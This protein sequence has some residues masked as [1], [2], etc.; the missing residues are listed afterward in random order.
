MFDLPLCSQV[1]KLRYRAWNDMTVGCLALLH[2]TSHRGPMRIRQDFF[3]FMFMSNRLS[4]IAQTSNNSCNSLTEGAINKMTSAYSTTRG[5]NDGRIGMSSKLYH[6]MVLGA[7]DRPSNKPIWPVPIFEIWF[8]DERI[9]NF[10]PRRPT[11]HVDKYKKLSCCRE[12]AR[13]FVP[14]NI[15]LSHKVIWNDT[16][17]YGVCKS[18]LVFHWNYVSRTRVPFLKYSSSK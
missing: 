7:R 9:T 10:L 15:S 3:S 8:D 16:L 18:L 2:L 11:S 1:S 17:E 13:C 4:S 14:L 12:T 5:N 6:T